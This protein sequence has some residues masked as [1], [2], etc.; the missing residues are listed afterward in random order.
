MPWISCK[1]ELKLKWTKYC[2]FSAA[3]NDNINDPNRHKTICSCR[4]FINKRQPKLSKLSSKGFEDQ[5]VAMSI[6]KKKRGNEITTNE[7]RYFLESNFVGVNNFFVLVY[8][9]QDQNC[10]RFV[11]LKYYLPKGIIDHYNVI[12]NGNMINQLILI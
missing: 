9:Y 5:F 4:H 7:Y 8:S 12:I 11:T 2:V 3:G 10:K 6:Q 1:V